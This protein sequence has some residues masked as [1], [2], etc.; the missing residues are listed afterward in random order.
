MNKRLKLFLGATPLFLGITLAS[1]GGTPFI[2]EGEENFS[3][4]SPA[5]APTL[6]IFDTVANKSG[7]ETTSNVSQIP[8]YLQAGTYNYV[9]FDSINALKLTNNAKKANYTYQTMLT[10]GNFHL[11]GFNNETEPKVGDKIVTFGKGLIPDLAFKTCYPELFVESNLDNIK[12]VEAVNNTVPVLKSGLLE[13]EKIDYV[14][15][16]QPALF[17]VISSNNTDDNT[18]NNITDVKNLNEKIKEITDG[19]FDYIPQAAIFVKDDYLAAKPNYVSNFLEDVKKQMKAAR[20]PELTT[21]SESMNKVEDQ[22]SKYGFTY[23]VV[24]KLQA[25]GNNQF[26][27][28]DPE[29]PVSIDNINEFL[30]SINAGFEIS[31]K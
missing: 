2:D 14:F 21:I 17:N 10:G 31:K 1:C 29:K 23:K 9:V 11:A 13:G 15:I 24:E 26:G 25:D 8:G 27:I 12:Y 18:E 7:A 16:A 19:K 20:T 30:S 4:I 28:M 22:A 5:G 3:L 6:S